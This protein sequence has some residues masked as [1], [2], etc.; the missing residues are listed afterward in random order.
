MTTL[1]LRYLGQSGV[2]DG[3]LAF[4]P[5]LARP[6]VFFDGELRHP[7]RFR[8]AMSA[9]HDIKRFAYGYFDENIYYN[10]P[11]DFLPNEHDP[12]RL[13]AMRRMDIILAVGRTDGL[14][15]SNEHLSHILWGKGIGNALRTWDGFAH[16]W[17]VWAK[18]LPL[19]IGGHD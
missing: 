5:N 9:L 12:W 8:E 7:L 15:G 19:Y 13:D 6:P 18:M 17:P 11:T 16:D 14:L 10:S 2:R 3:A 1:D 4:A